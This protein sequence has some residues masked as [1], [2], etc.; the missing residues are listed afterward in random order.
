MRRFPNGSCG[1]SVELP[2]AGKAVAMGK[3]G[4]ER[5]DNQNIIL[6]NQH[7]PDVVPDDPFPHPGVEKRAADLAGDQFSLR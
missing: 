1:A 3:N 6:E 4:G 2:I 7:L 5:P